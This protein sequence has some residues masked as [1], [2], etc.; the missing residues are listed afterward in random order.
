MY[1]FFN[2][3]PLPANLRDKNVS[4]NFFLVHDAIPLSLQLKWIHGW[5]IICQEQ[6]WQMLR[7]G[8]VRE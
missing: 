1:P 6:C 3:G 7:L 8:V 5:D 2:G 4:V